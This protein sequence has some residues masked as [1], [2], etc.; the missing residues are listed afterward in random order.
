[1]IGWILEVSN[2]IILVMCFICIVNLLSARRIPKANFETLSQLVSILVPLRNEI[3]NVNGVIESLLNQSGLTEFEVIALNDGS[4]D[5][6]GEALRSITDPRFSY[7]NGA[8]LPD[9]WLGKNF[10]CHQLA[11]H[12]RGEILVFVDADV[13]LRADAIHASIHAMK[14]WGWNFI[15]PYPRQIAISF[16]ERLAQPLLQWSWFVTLPLRLAEKLRKTSMVVAN[17]QFLIISREA[18]LK[19]GGHS[20][21]KNEVLDDLEIARALIRSGFYGNVAE[22]SAIAECRMYTHTDELVEGYSKSQWRAFRNPFGA[23]L[24][25]ILLALTSIYPLLLG[26]SG[27][28][29]GWYGYFAIVG[30]RILVGVKTRSTISTAYLHPLSAALWIFL[31]YL[32]WYRKLRGTLSW[33]GRTV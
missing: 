13:R 5:G 1:M 33:R 3:T 4:T 22:A 14:K 30:T 8:Q 12:S 31:I 11:A 28:I 9:G 18:Y 21:V 24:V 19:S 10:A 29:S 2:L 15:S 32:S 20:S 16:V 25:S 7:F 27:N 17:G 6:T 26:L 23:V